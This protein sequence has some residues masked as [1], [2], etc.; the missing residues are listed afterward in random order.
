MYEL[1]KAGF[2]AVVFCFSGFAKA[3]DLI[4]SIVIVDER[5]PLTERTGV[6][7][8]EPAFLPLSEVSTRAKPHQVDPFNAVIDI[9]FEP[10]LSVGEAMNRVLGFIGYDLFVSGNSI[11]PSAEALFLRP[12]PYVHQ[13]FE[14]TRVK[15]VLSALV[16]HRFIVV[17]DH[18]IRAVTAD[19]SPLKRRYTIVEEQ[20]KK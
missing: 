19:H 7:L 5:F 14:G 9:D 15:D 11:D 3:Q 13:T 17:I 16:G 6:V 12:L 10:S 2:L 20:L 1:K 8:Q 4:T 18:N